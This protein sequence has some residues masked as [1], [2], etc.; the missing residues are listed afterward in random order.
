V[1]FGKFVQAVGTRY[2]GNYPGGAGKAGNLPRMAI[3][4]IWNEPNWPTWLAPQY[5]Y[6]PQLG[7]TIP[8][9]PIQYRRLF[10]AARKGLDASGHKTDFVMLGETQP[11]GSSS[12]NES[13]PMR[14]GQFLRELFCVRGNT[15]SMRGADAAARGCSDFTRH[16]AMRISAF[17]HHPYTKSAPPTWVDPNP[18]SFTLGNIAKL[19]ALLDRIAA[20]T[21]RLPSKLPIMVTEMGYSTN[22]PNPFRGVPLQTQAEYINESDYLAYKQPRVYSM[23][24]FLYRDSPP[25]KKAKKG[26]RAYW[27]TFQTGIT[28]LDGTPKPSYAAYA[29]PIWVR[30][31]HD[32]QGNRQL[33][34]WAQARF[35]RYG[36]PSDGILFQFRPQGSQTWSNIGALNP[37]SATYGFVDITVPAAPYMPGGSI[38]AVWGGPVAPYLAYSRTVTIP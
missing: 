34:L 27:A 10:Y 26:S 36:A 3:W 4:S 21:H 14:P 35:R 6:S 7:R 2:S 24:Q 30:S 9:S 33:E 31:G 5:L 25:V 17:A 37:I 18:D 8:Y 11:L 19:P 20:G 32:S 28:Y 13:T 12:G 1:Q 23:T 22:P 16:G 29:L 38:R 15:R